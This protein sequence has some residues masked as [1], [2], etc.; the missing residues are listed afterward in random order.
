LFLLF[1]RRLLAIQFP[2]E[3]KLVFQNI[4]NLRIQFPGNLAVGSWHRDGDYNHNPEEVNIFLPLTNA[5]GTNT[6]WTE[7]IPHKKDYQPL[8]ANYGEF[9]L[10]DGVKLEHGNK[11]NLT[12]ETR[13]SLDFRVIPFTKYKELPGSSINAHKAFKIGDYYSI[14]EL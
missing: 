12:A 3:E 5:Y 13:V 9:W 2:L 7:T 4:P 1:V 8:S 11:I 14:M 6:I 10:W